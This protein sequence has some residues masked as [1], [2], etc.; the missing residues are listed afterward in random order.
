MSPCGIYFHAAT[1]IMLGHFSEC[2][3]INDSGKW[4][5]IRKNGEPE[6]VAGLPIE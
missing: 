6:T 5:D 4:Y 2:I 1:A 3:C